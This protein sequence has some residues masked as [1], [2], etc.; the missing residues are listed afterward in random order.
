MQATIDQ[1][2]VFIMIEE[3]Y[4]TIENFFEKN[5]IYINNSK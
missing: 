2:I 3:K 5:S 1:I 4:G